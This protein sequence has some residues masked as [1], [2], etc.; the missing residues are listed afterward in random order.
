MFVVFVDL[1]NEIN[2][3]HERAYWYIKVKGTLNIY[4]SPFGILE[5]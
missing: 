5:I 2:I 3:V 4:H 1:V